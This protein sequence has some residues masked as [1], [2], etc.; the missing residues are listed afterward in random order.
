MYHMVL[1][2]K[3]RWAVANGSLKDITLKVDKV[4]SINSINEAYRQASLEIYNGI[5][6]YTEDPTV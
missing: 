1:D 4:I 5:L 2:S 6:E 3:I